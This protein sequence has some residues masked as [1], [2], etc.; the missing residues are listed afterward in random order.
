MYKYQIQIDNRNNGFWNWITIYA[1]NDT[2][3]LLQ[4][5]WEVANNDNLKDYYV[6]QI[7]SKEEINYPFSSRNDI[8]Q[9]S[10]TE[11]KE[12]TFFK[13][14]W[15]NYTEQLKKLAATEVWSNDTYQKVY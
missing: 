10:E 6:S 13:V 4:A 12:M 2:E 5:S 1:K 11:D 15:N 3:A 9:S 7:F 14:N 8:M